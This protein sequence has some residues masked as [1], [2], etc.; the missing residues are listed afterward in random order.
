[1][2]EFLE[3]NENIIKEELMTYYKFRAELLQH[4]N[5]RI[6]AVGNPTGTEYDYC[7]QKGQLDELHN[8]LFFVK[9]YGRHT[10]ISKQIESQTKLEEKL[11]ND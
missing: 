6:E 9:K 1:M 4:I 8:L 5:N 7:T 11:K 3:N 10:I 2:V